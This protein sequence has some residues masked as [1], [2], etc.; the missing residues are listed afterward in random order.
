MSELSTLKQQVKQLTQRLN[1]ITASARKIF[2]L[3]WQS[4]LIPGSKLQVSNPSE[5][6]EFITVQQILDA[7]LSYRQNQLIEANISVLGNDVTVD[8]GAKWIINNINYE[9][10]SD[11]TETVDYAE[12]GYTRN[13]IL[14]GDQSNLIYRVIGPETEGVSPT[15]GVPLNTVLVTVINVTDSTIGYVPPVIGPYDSDDIINVSGVS[16]AKV[17]NALNTLN[18]VKENASNKQNSLIFDGTGN[19]FTTV[20]VVNSSIIYK[21]TISQIRALTGTLSNNY[22]YTTDIRQEGNW[23]Y[24]ASDT[25]SS[26]NT[27]TIL[28]T[29]DGK[30]IKRIFN[31]TILPEWFGAIG[32]GTTNDGAAIQNAIN[33]AVYGNEIEFNTIK[34]YL[35]SAL[36]LKS[37]VALIGNSVNG[38]DHTQSQPK[39]K[40]SGTTGD[41]LTLVSGASSPYSPTK[42]VSIK[43][44]TI[45]GNNTTGTLIKIGTFR[46]VIQGCNLTN[47]S[48]IIY[49]PNTTGWIGENRIKSN[50]IYTFTDA[51]YSEG[52][53][54]LDGHIEDNFIFT[55]TRGIFLTDAAGWDIHGNHLYGITGTNIEVSGVLFNI[56]NNYLD[57]IDTIGIKATVT[58]AVSGSVI[59][60]N[61]ISNTATNNSVG[62]DIISTSTGKVLISNNTI[63]AATALTN[64]TGIRTTGAATFFGSILN[65]LV[66]QL[67]TPYSLHSAN[68]TDFTEVK[69]NRLL[70]NGNEIRFEHNGQSSWGNSLM[71]QS[72]SP[73]TVYSANAGTL[74]I[75]RAGSN[76]TVWV[77]L[78]GT[79]NTGWEQIFSGKATASKTGAMTLAGDL[80]GSA[81]VPTV[82]KLTTTLPTSAGGYQLV[83]KNTTTGAIE[84]ITSGFYSKTDNPVFTTRIAT[85]E[86][87]INAS[88]ATSGGSFH[89]LTRNDGTGV[90]EQVASTTFAS[91]ASPAFTGVPTAPTATA[92]TNTTQIATTA[93]VQA[94]TRPYK[95]NAGS[96]IQSS[97]SDPVATVM[98]NG[99]SGSIVWIRT[100]SGTYDGTLSGAFTTNKTMFLLSGAFGNN[101][102]ADV[103]VI[104]NNVI[105][106]TT[107]IGITATDSVLN[108]SYEVRVY[109]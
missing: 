12:T 65:N 52:I 16:G 96:I 94:A 80:G 50:N 64:T 95:S 104:S 78:T 88:P 44:L 90:T 28:V 32:D 70:M 51:I 56:R 75:N 7:A 11:F 36:T 41:F 38:V 61:I 31:N 87:L 45:D 40:Y 73:E 53:Y 8:S 57:N 62:I 68:N 109:P 22:F 54:G 93:F 27:G 85:P 6:S 33:T 63:Y 82:I 47:A 76:G 55:G 98:E 19:K 10:A 89:L 103:Q 26:D 101:G 58:S 81:D 46:S 105:R 37:D 9:L 71:A 20:D 1:D 77:K 48:K 92:L 14:V 108:G 49:Y 39:L 97:T 74:G 100:G 21:R 18:A 13:D 25:T 15:P 5:I 102:K 107:Y 99:L 24:D 2:Q 83:S 3:P 69:S 60:S 72:V 84:S 86:L 30:R 43:N 35:S 66:D 34:T 42:G 17:T 59:Q 4:T 29:A 79:G 91:T 67:D 23:Y 106:I